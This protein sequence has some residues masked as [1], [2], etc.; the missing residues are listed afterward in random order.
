[1]VDAP[2]WFRR[3]IED[4]PEHL[5]AVV[6]GVDVHYRAWGAPEA[7][8]VLLVH[9]GGANSAWWDHIGP[10]LAHDFRVLA[11]DLT[12][13]GDSGWKPAYDR[14]Q[15]AFEIA[16]VAAAEGMDRPMYV[17]HSMGGWISVLLGVERPDAM[18]GMIVIDSPMME[19]PPEEEPMSRRPEKLKVYPTLGDAVARFRTVP[20]QAVV[21]PYV[22]EHVAVES[23]KQ[24][25]GGW[26]WKFD[27]AVFGDRS[28]HR[29]LLPDLTAPMALIRCEHGMCTADMAERMSEMTPGGV[30]IIELPEAGHH[31]M[32]DQPLALA[33]SL[34]A[35]LAVFPASD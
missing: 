5:V 27:T 4:K 19:A 26:S 21:L 22:A 20:E 12:G 31:A 17:G 23:L 28:W 3:A 2:E 24:V 30:P 1:M 25:E 35:L 9:G 6:D 14:P 15:W 32:M 10:F 18:R 29:H 34:R 11:P 13:H 16:G 33:A 8:G 7:P